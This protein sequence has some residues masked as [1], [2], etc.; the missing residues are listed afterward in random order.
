MHPPVRQKVGI[1]TN[2][3]IRLR[4]TTSLVSVWKTLA[5][6][7]PVRAPSYLRC[8]GEVAFQPSEDANSASSALNRSDCSQKGPCPTPE[9]TDM[10]ASF[11]VA[12]MW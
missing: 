3:R 9:K 11:T 1:P 12:E 6:V 8:N 2:E 10:E 5:V 7:A 4:Q